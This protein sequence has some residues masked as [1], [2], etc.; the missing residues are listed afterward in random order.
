MIRIGLIAATSY[1][2]DQIETWAVHEGLRVLGKSGLLVEVEGDLAT[3]EKSL[4]IKLHALTHGWHTNHQ[5]HL[6][7]GVKAVAGLSTQGRGYPH[8][9][10]IDNPVPRLATTG[11]APGLMPDQVLAGYHVTDT[12]TGKGQVIGI[13]EWGVSFQQSDI[14]L[15]SQVAKLPQAHVT[16]VPIDGYQN[17]FSS[18]DG[19]EATLDIS[20]AHAMAPE[21]DIRVYMAPAATAHT[22]WPMEVT[23]LLN[24]VLTDAVKPTVLSISYGDGEDQ[25]HASDL[26][27]WD[28]LFSELQA[29]GTTVLVSSGDQGAYGLHVAE[30]PQ[31]RRVDA[32]ASCP[33]GVAVGG[34][35]LFMN[36][37]KFEGEE[38]WSNDVNMGAGGGGYSTVFT[39]PSYQDALTPQASMR[40]VPDLAAVASLDTMCFLVYNSSYTMVGGTSWAA[41]LVAG[42]L[43]RLV[44]KHGGP[45]GDIHEML[46]AHG[47]TLC[48]D[49]TIGNNNCYAVTG[50]ECATGWDPVTGWGS[51]LYDQWSSVW[52]TTSTPGSSPTHLSVTPTVK[53]LALAQSG[54]YSSQMMALQS[55]AK[56]VY[57][58]Q[59][60]MSAN[61]VKALAEHPVGYYN[62]IQRNAAQLWVAGIHH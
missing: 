45:V 38:A 62:T 37:T 25:F 34:T 58:A 44:E 35:A 11:P 24:T 30:Q 23:K 39:R 15:F 14:D 13:A 5:P 36:G 42:L 59:E 20:W 52:G 60:A 33:H 48:R 29:R 46:Y 21:A 43:T 7:V 40:G 17:T 41:P 32:P 4:R 8:S 57:A 18:A 2:L 53:E 56:V 54:A 31:V 50:Y 28:H 6:P 19:P 10:V 22:S 51:P 27:A 26:R 47:S 3:I 16:V 9:R 49:I 55:A 61:A 12:A 1:F